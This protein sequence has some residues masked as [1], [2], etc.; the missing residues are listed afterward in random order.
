MA[1]LRP[2]NPVVWRAPVM[3]DRK[4]LKHGIKFTINDCKWESPQRDFMQIWRAH[5]LEAARSPACP[6]NSPKH[7]QVI[8]S[9]K[10]GSTLFV[11]GDLLLVLQRCIWMKAVI[12]FSRA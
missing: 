9:A 6:V 11:I 10:T 12:H 1:M 7:R 5:Y 8:P 3:R 2:P 4:H